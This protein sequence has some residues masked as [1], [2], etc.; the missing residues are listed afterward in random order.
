MVTIILNKINRVCLKFYIQKV[1]SVSHCTRES[2]MIRLRMNKDKFA[3]IPNAFD[4]NY[5]DP[6]L[7]PKVKKDSSFISICYFSR[8]T[9]RK[10][11]DFLFFA[12]PVLLKKYKN[13]K[14]Y[15]YGK[16]P[17]LPILLELIKEMPE[18]NRIIIFPDYVKSENIPSTLAKHDILL[19]ASLTES[20]CLLILEAI[21]CGMFVVSTSNY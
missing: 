9:T 10:G 11:T 15:I 21:A 3:V 5:F 19:S 13:L 20:F 6:N 8:M 17:K 12:I 14:F 4:F 2:A 16:G 1:I 7:R 18:K